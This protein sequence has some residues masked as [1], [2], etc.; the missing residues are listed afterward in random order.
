MTLDIESFRYR[1]GSRYIGSV[2]HPKNAAS[3]IDIQNRLDR[4]AELQMAVLGDPSSASSVPM[5]TEQAD[6]L[7]AVRG[8]ENEVV[9]LTDAAAPHSQ[10]DAPVTTFESQN[11]FATQAQIPTSA[12]RQ[13]RVRPEVSLAQGTNLAR[14]VALPRTA[15]VEAAQLLRSLGRQVPS[16]SSM[17]SGKIAPKARPIQ[18]V[19]MEVAPGSDSSRDNSSS[20]SLSEAP[21]PLPQAP[22]IELERPAN[23][24][25]DVSMNHNERTS[26]GASPSGQRSCHAEVEYNTTLPEVEAQKE[27]SPIRRNE[28]VRHE[29]QEMDVDQQERDNVDTTVS[30]ESQ[31]GVPDPRYVYY[32]KKHL[33]LE[34]QK[35]ILSSASWLPSEPGETFVTSNI[36]VSLLRQVSD[37]NGT[38]FGRTSIHGAFVT[39]LRD[40]IEE[41]NVGE[42]PEEDES[43]QVSSDED[44]TPFSWPSSSPHKEQ[45]TRTAEYLPPDSSAIVP[46][47]PR[48]VENLPPDSSAHTPPLSSPPLGSQGSADSDD[49][50]L[51]E[52]VPRPWISRPN[53]KAP[54]V[55]IKGSQP[56]RRSSKVQIHHPPTSTHQSTV[57]DSAERLRDKPISNIHETVVKRPYDDRTGPDNYRK[58]RVARSAYDW[59]EDEYSKEDPRHSLNKQK[60]ARFRQERESLEPI[61]GRPNSSYFGL[62]SH[63]PNRW[64]RENHERDERWP[65]QP[66][67]GPRGDSYR[68][69]YSDYHPPLSRPRTQYVSDNNRSA[70]RRDDYSPSSSWSSAQQGTQL[71]RNAQMD[72]RPSPRDRPPQASHENVFQRYRDN[73]RWP[74]VSAAMPNDHLSAIADPSSQRPAAPSPRNPPPAIPGLGLFSTSTNTPPPRPTASSSRRIPEQIPGLGTAPPTGPRA[75]R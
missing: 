74:S 43:S 27:I 30:E 49:S 57:P 56:E 14:P 63:E 45:S 3:D 21:Q 22:P 18:E 69:S 41:D 68:P 36:P 31:R 46:P 4:L 71:V 48:P 53:Q 38:A 5:D 42:L 29:D 12:F 10:T 65:M 50:V 60:S 28:A 26:G 13:P 6:D 73:S 23:D 35:L 34:Q 32:A 8:D 52:S 9:D 67:R 7:N 51:P 62:G 72:R 40:A 17:S 70:S 33:P 15:N 47:G 55:F 58:K 75:M 61:A 20:P 64:P 11:V 66:P 19:H 44:D 1:K 39:A 54:E 24:L 16:Q 25:P 59:G 37:A 2:G